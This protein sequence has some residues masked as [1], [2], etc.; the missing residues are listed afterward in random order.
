[1][2]MQMLLLIWILEEYHLEWAVK[3]QTDRGRRPLRNCASLSGRGY[4]DWKIERVE[5]N[6]QI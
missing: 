5:R 3:S 6:G 1:M 2:Q 4:K